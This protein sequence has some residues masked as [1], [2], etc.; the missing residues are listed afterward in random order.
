MPSGARGLMLAVMMS[1]LMSSLTSVFNSSSTIFTVDVWMRMRPLA[2]DV[3]Q[4][5]VSR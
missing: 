3:E 1:A 5:I 4:M 2:G